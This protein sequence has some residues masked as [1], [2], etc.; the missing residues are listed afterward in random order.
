MRQGTFIQIFYLL[1]LLFFIS[2]DSSNIKNSEK[3]S[4][5]TKDS[6]QT[7]NSIES[8]ETISQND[9]GLI[10]NNGLRKILTTH[11]DTIISINTFNSKEE[12]QLLFNPSEL[13][14]IE[15][16]KSE[17]ILYKKKFRSKLT[18][19]SSKINFQDTAFTLQT[20]KWN[21][22]FN[23]PNYNRNN[24]RGNS[25]FEYKGYINDLKVYVLENWWHAGGYT[26]GESFLVDSVTNIKYTLNS[27]LDGSN[28]PPIVSPNNK[29][30]ISFAN[31]GTEPKGFC[32]L[33][34][35]KII[36]SKD[37]FRYHEYMGFESDKWSIE[38]LIWV[39]DN[40]FLLKTN[41]LTYNDKNGN[42]VDNF[43][44]LKTT[45]PKSKSN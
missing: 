26:L 5:Q 21:H 11:F 9:S 6:L 24:E 8:K 42:W 33:D 22:T 17:F 14:F 29:Y 34:I 28:E 20:S 45:I 31:D 18:V 13:V 38:E 25:W 2:C 41:S 43:N 44:Y 12:S 35:V 23:K 36:K 40:T 4:I 1:G 16:S 7:E 27:L 39:D 10:K 32:R 19:D 3:D 37:S 30:L 15:I